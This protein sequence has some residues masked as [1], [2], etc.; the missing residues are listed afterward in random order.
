MSYT[1]MN[2]LERYVQE[3]DALLAVESERGSAVIASC[4]VED[5][6]DSLVE[7]HETSPCLYPPQTAKYKEAGWV[8]RKFDKLR[9]QG[10]LTAQ[11]SAQLQLLR[12]I[13]NVF[14]HNLRAT[15]FEYP[16]IVKLLG[17]AAGTAR[18]AFRALLDES[19][20]LL[21]GLLYEKHHEA[22]RAYLEHV[23]PR[24]TGAQ[25]LGRIAS[26]ELVPILVS[27][28]G[29]IRTFSADDGGAG[30]RVLFRDSEAV[31]LLAFR[32]GA[33]WYEIASDEWWG[34]EAFPLF[35][36]AVNS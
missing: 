12:D 13:R 31:R 22:H 27:H 5:I 17:G 4:F 16:E 35:A 11:Q 3:F 23:A 7:R 36:S 32:L 18:E 29:D 2:R 14:A 20:S 26:G 21:Y 24:I 9:Q 1:Q 6:V 28:D 34:D 8:L 19:A 33:E 15:A 25:L 10:V 30:F